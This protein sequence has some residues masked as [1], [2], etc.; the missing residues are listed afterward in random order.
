MRSP[1]ESSVVTAVDWDP[2]IYGI[3][4]LNSCRARTER[5]F[6]AVST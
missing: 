4:A 6:S 3:R 5:L 2:N 1:H